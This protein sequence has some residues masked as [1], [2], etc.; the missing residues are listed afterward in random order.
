[1]SKNKG[2][3]AK[4]VG[5]GSKTPVESKLAALTR[6]MQEMREQLTKE[7]D[8]LQADV[9]AKQ[10]KL[11]ELNEQIRQV[12][13]GYAPV[14][15]PYVQPYVPVPSVPWWWPYSP[16]V[17]PRLDPTPWIYT[18]TSGNEVNLPT[19]TNTYADGLTGLLRN[20]PYGS[21]VTVDLHQDKALSVY[22][23][24]VAGATSH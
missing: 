2:V 21:E 9:L 20:T 8:A 18:V 23:L 6:Q 10:V 16:P 13:P 11:A 14:L 7:R 4:A 3:E 1:M 24:S 5:S 17:Y 12:S 22:S 19:Q 15:Q